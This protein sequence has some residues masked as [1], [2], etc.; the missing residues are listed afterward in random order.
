VNHQLRGEASFE[1][2]AWLERECERLGVPLLVEHCDTQQLAAAQGDG[3]E[4]AARDARYRLLVQMAETAGARYVV[5]AHTRD[6]QVETV[7]H[8]L[9]RGTG[10]RGLAGMPRNR[11]LSASVALVRPLLACTRRDVLDYLAAIDQPYRDDATNEQLHFTRNRI[12]HE[13]LP[14]IR[15]TYNT[16]VED[17]LLRLAELAGDAQTVIE[18]A[19]GDLLD[20]CMVK[21]EAGRVELATA[22]LAGQPMLVVCEVF[23]LAWRAAGFSEQAMTR[24][25]WQKLAQFAQTSAPAGAL[26][27]PGNV[28]ARRD[29]AGQ[30]SLTAPRLP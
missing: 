19:A 27:L 22:P 11:L 2:E 4:A 7:L 6:D 15:A 29:S 20:A 30:L 10:L 24:E 5:L 21:S 18:H 17:A 16:D 14:A 1:D 25:W 13:L 23:R 3:L 8:R 12:R 9:L 26:N 28:I